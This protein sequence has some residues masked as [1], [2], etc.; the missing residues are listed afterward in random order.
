M[1][2]ANWIWIIALVVIIVIVAMN[3]KDIKK[4]FKGKGDGTNGTG[5]EVGGTGGG[6]VINA[7]FIADELYDLMKGITIYPQQVKVLAYLKGMLDGSDAYF[8]AVWNAFGTKDG[9][10]LATWVD[11]ELYTGSYGNKLSQRASQLGLS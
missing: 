1:K 8:T 7:Q 2:K 4:I 11:E 9:D 10:N 5:T 6:N 3:W